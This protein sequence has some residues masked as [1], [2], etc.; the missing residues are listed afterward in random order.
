MSL[1][2]TFE[3]FVIVLMTAL[4]IDAESMPFVTA[5]AFASLQV[6]LYPP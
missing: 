4:D 5:K 6:E 3:S 2:T 1:S